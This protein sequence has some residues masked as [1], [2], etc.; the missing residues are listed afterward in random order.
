[1]ERT[2]IQSNIV[3]TPEV[4]KEYYIWDKVVGPMDANIVVVDSVD[5]VQ[6]TI[7]SLLSVDA[8]PFT[9]PV[10]SLVWEWDKSSHDTDWDAVYSELENN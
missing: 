9:V 5:G 8:K 10:A 2:F 6:A 3:D 7:R 4:G 1:V